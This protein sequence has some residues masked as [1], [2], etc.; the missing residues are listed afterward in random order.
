[1]A[2]SPVT[3]QLDT[4]RGV[5]RTAL[6]FLSL[7]PCQ[8]ELRRLHRWLDSWPA[9][10]TSSPARLAKGTT[11][12]FGDTTA[13]AGVRCSLLKASSAGWAVSPWAAVTAPNPG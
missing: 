6:D 3:V 12:S 10:A 5:L 7:E 1:M 9:L 13:A 11:L 4:R 8:P 2:S